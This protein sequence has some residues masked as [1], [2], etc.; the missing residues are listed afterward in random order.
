MI[1]VAIL[2][3][4]AYFLK[5]LPYVRKD[6]NVKD[7]GQVSLALTQLVRTHL[8]NLNRFQTVGL[9]SATSDPLQS[10]AQKRQARRTGEGLSLEYI[11]NFYSMLYRCFYYDASPYNGTAHKPCSKRFIDYAKSPEALFRQQLFE[12]IK[13]QP[14]FALRLGYTRPNAD[15]SWEIRPQ[16]LKQLLSGKRSYA[17]LSDADFNASI[18]QKGVDIRMGIDIASITLKKQANTF[19][20]VTG[21]E[22]FVPAA[23][24]ARREG[25]KV[26]LDPLGR[27][28]SDSLFEHIDAC[29]SAFRP[30]TNQPSDK[31]KPTSKTKVKTPTAKLR[32]T[33][34]NDPSA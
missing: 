2:I 26:T 24:L 25:C 21:D 4:G 29:W 5:R 22:D 7:A 16:V 33:D 23:K 3:D 1:R 9:Y 27:S 10:P 34:N 18:R 11:P 32:R 12:R 28:V 19:I 17:S 15:C 6:V 13:Q 30:T 31:N 20:L 14:N 8:E